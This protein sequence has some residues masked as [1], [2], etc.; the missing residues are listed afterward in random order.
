ME[1]YVVDGHVYDGDA[2]R[3]TGRHHVRTR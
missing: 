3:Q 2:W 1:E